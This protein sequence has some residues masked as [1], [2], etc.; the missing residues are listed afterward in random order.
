[1]RIKSGQMPKMYANMSWGQPTQRQTLSAWSVDTFVAPCLE[2]RA[3]K[4]NPSEVYRIV[5]Q[6]LSSLAA[7]GLPRYQ[8]YTMEERRLLYPNRAWAV[9]LADGT[10]HVVHL[11]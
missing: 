11:S 2:D 7:Y 4:R 5:W 8:P 6:Q 1:M 9:T 3:V 10:K